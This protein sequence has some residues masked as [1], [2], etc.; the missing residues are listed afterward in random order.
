MFNREEATT[1]I[2]R[3]LEGEMSAEEKKAFEYR[4]DTEQDLSDEFELHLNVRR[5]FTWNMERA[6][7]QVM[8]DRFHQDFNEES[9]V[10]VR[11]KK[12]RT[13][14][15][16]RI[17]MVAASVSL[18]ITAGSLVIYNL[19]QQNDLSPNHYA[20]LNRKE[21]ES[22][23]PASAQPKVEKDVVEPAIVRNVATAFAIDA[24]GIMLTNYHVVEG[25]KYVYIEKFQDSLQSYVAEVID[26]DKRLDIAV[27]RVTDPQFKALKTI[28]F[29]FADGETMIG[30]K[31]FTLGYPK[32]EI[33]YS[34]GPISSLTGFRSDTIALQLSLPVNP[35]NSGA[36]VFSEN[37]ELI[38]VITG[39]NTQT[40]G[41]AYSV[42]A[43][44][45]LNFLNESDK[46]EFKPLRR[47]VLRGKKIT[48]QVKTL[49]QFIFVVKA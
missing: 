6:K 35:G 26:Y 40:D 2:E 14:S 21:G 42:K 39:K 48:D 10:R 47:S 15:P 9:P 37:G 13:L 34:E 22:V 20:T 41:E 32:K 17:I 23:R 31:V 30:Q 4:L 33:V 28:P 49:D 46:F 43:E 16:V 18:L 11:E 29:S 7:L 36:P 5:S 27:L 38:G 25:K 24:N 3:Y 12:V 19:I 8:L 1:L 44:H 45:I